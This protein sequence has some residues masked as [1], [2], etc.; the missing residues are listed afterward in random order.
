MSAKRDPRTG[1]W[2]YR[3]VVKLPDG[4]K[5]R[6]FGTPAKFNLADTKAGAEE[7][8]RLAIAQVRETGTVAPAPPTPAAEPAKPVPTLAEYARDHWIPLAK[9]DNKPTT[10]RAKRKV[11]ARILPALGDLPLDRIDRLAVDQWRQA[12]V[13]R[14]LAPA[15]VNNSLRILHHLLAS[16]T[17]HG[18]VTKVPKVKLVAMPPGKVDFL[19]KDELDRLLAVPAD[20]TFRLMVL[21]AAQ[22]GLRI[23]ELRGLHWDDIDL[24]GRRLFVRRTFTEGKVLAPKSGRAREVPLPQAS[25]ASLTAWREHPHG[26]LVFPNAAGRYLPDATVYAWLE[27]ATTAAGI[28]SIGWH[29]LRHTYASHLAQRGVSLRAIQKLLGH[30]SIVHTERY[31]HLA[32]GNL[33]DAVTALDAP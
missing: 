25:L 9:V 22:T 32:P 19:T 28:R 17:E 15:T 14:G 23:G 21:V 7:A 1:R 18:F 30:S 16:A 5:H 33:H 11:L 8:E 13:E 3:K 2:F 10:V 26:T 29:A 24:A 31:S 4:G 20:P 12:L 6:L 27:A